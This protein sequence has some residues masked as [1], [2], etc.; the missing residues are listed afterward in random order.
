[1]EFYD[2]LQTRIDMSR[3][4]GVQHLPKVLQ[5]LIDDGGDEV[6]LDSLITDSAR[7]ELE[8][9]T[10]SIDHLYYWSLTGHLQDVKLHWEIMKNIGV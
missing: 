10:Y 6:Y 9:E 2:Y 3:D 7:K 8:A 4:S 5:K 1:M